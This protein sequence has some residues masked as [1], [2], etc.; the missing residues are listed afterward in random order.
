MYLGGTIALLL[1]DNDQT[2]AI[3]DE[4]GR[5][6]QKLYFLEIRPCAYMYMYMYTCD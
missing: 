3:A 1:F 6:A 4:F 2:T 5:H